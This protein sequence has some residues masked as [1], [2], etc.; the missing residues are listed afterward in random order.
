MFDEQGFIRYAIQYNRSCA[1]I[2]D[3]SNFKLYC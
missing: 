2:D 3:R 1:G